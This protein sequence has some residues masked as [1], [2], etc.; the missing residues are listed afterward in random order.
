[1]SDTLDFTVMAME[2]DILEIRQMLIT[3]QAYATAFPSDPYIQPPL[4]TAWL[5]YRLKTL[6]TTQAG[7]IN[8]VA[9][10]AATAISSGN[11]IGQAP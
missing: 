4:V 8:G 2:R 1:M 11:A 7:V 5:R 9:P 3:A 10:V 6:L